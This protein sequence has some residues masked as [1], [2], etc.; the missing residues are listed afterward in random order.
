MGSGTRRGLLAALLIGALVSPPALRPS[1]ASSSTD[2]ASGG[3]LARS[4]VVGLRLV[5]QFFPEI[6]QM[7]S[8]GRNSTAVG[9]PL[10]TRAVFYTNGDG[11]KLVTVTVDRYG[12][13]SE[14]AA[15]YR[16]ALDQSEAAPGFAVIPL[17]VNVGRKAFAGTSTMDGETHLGLGALDGDLIIGA[18]LA[19]FDPALDDLVNLVGLARA[20]D[21]AANASAGR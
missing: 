21:A 11:S 9:K 15:A 1:S 19:G 14:A 20:E 10:A 4:F 6:T 17:P 3:L 5:S 18:T 16:I 2:G 8:T 12:S 7:A 13:A